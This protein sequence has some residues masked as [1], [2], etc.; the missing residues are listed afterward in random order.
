MLFVDFQQAFDRVN[1]KHLEIVLKK[2]KAQKK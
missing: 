2:F 1:R